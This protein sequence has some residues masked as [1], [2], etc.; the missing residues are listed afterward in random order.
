MVK[1]MKLYFI[2][3]FT[4]FAIVGC[5]LGEDPVGFERD[6]DMSVIDDMLCMNIAQNKAYYFSIFS[7][8]NKDGSGLRK[9][10]DGSE[11]IALNNKRCMPLFWLPASEKK[12][13]I[14]HYGLLSRLETLP[15]FRKVA[16]I[17]L[18]NSRVYNFPLK[19][20]DYFPSFISE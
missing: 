11:L 14:I 7:I 5:T 3:I 18:K 9:T 16:A 1:S 4:C 19:R 2:V 10:I 8:K 17:R 13:Y 6:A 20:E 12:E 15:S